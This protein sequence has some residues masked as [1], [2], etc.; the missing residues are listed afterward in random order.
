MRR[1]EVRRTLASSKG[2]PRFLTNVTPSGPT[3]IWVLLYCTTCPALRSVRSSLSALVA[4]VGRPELLAA[5]GAALVV[6]LG[7]LGG[8]DVAASVEHE[9]A[10]ARGA[11]GAERPR[12]CSDMGV[13]SKRCTGAAARVGWS[14]VF[15]G[16]FTGLLMRTS[17]LPLGLRTCSDASPH[18]I[19][20]EEANGQRLRG[21]SS[22]IARVRWR[23]MPV[24]GRC[25]FAPQAHAPRP[26]NNGWLGCP[27]T[28]V[29]PVPR[30]EERETAAIGRM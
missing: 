4:L 19:Q 17:G 28:C 29:A 13:G 2:R 21:A 11:G 9:D 23:T 26:A 18:A 10:A 25:A 14:V 3:V 5:A 7:R 27:G 12:G 24:L 15:V 8:T 30:C 22:R 20:R 1:I 16:R 6:P